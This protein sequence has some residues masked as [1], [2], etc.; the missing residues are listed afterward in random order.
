M[1]KA[2]ALAY[3]VAEF[4]TAEQDPESGY[5]TMHTDGLAASGIGGVGVILF[6]PEKDILKYGVKL[7]FPTTNNEAKY[8]A[9]LMGL[10]VAKALGVRNLKLNTDSKLMTKQ[11]NSEYEVKEDK[12]KRYLALTS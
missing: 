10:Q 2:Q 9:I 12:M 3:F 1:I 7:Q 4:T 11:M 8:E 5:W 6:S